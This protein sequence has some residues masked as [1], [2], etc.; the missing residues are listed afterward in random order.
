MRNH[1]RRPSPAMIVACLAL[2]VALGGTGIAA[3]TQLARNSVGTAAQ[4]QRRHGA[5]IAN[6]AVDERRRVREQRG[7]LGQGREHRRSPRRLRARPASGRADGPAGAGRAG[8]SRPGRAGQPG[9]QVVVGPVTVRQASVDR[10]G[11]G[12]RQADPE[13]ALGHRGRSDADCNSGEQAIS[14][15]TGWSADADDLE[16]G[17]GLHE[18]GPDATS[19]GH[20]LDGEGRE[21]RTDGQAST[22]TLYALCYT[23]V[24]V[25]LVAR[26]SAPRRE[27]SCDASGA[28]RR[29]GCSLARSP[30]RSSASS[31]GA[32]RSRRTSSPA[33]RASR[34]SVSPT[35]RARRRSTACEAA[36]SRPRSSGRSTGES[37]STSRRRRFARR[38]RGSTCRSRSRSSRATRQIPPERLAEHA[39]VGELALDGRIRPVPGT[40]AVA[41]GARRAGLARVVCAAES[42]PE[43]ALAG[44]EPVPVRHLGEAVAYLRGE[45]EAPDLRAGA[46]GRARGG[47]R[48]RSRRRPRAGACEAGS[49]DR[50]RRLAQPPARRAR[51]VPG[52][53]C[54]PA[55]FPASFRRSRARRRSR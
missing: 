52:R 3:V 1:L 28:Y 7:Q 29:P 54:S 24:V 35:A 43:A 50:R 44:I 12:V 23:A 2:L 8:R 31:R 14:G 45:I 55:A 11:L 16:L 17:D 21:Q 47:R 48:R 46:R 41:E 51:P 34:S 49:R 30:T 10:A 22:F 9:P 42:A 36:S 32:S 53:R 18:A 39:A 13:H 26:H 40:L 27:C 33:S 38:G 20:G 6:S 4:E 37:P 19:A 25:E 15:G 5:K